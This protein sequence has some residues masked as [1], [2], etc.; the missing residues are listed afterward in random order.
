MSE[1]KDLND[2][3]HLQET[4]GQESSEEKLK[5][6][7]ATKN[8][9]EENDLR[10]EGVSRKKKNSI[11]KIF[12]L[13]FGSIMIIGLVLFFS[14]IY[15]ALSKVPELSGEYTPIVSSKIYDRN[16]KLITML[17]GEENRVI[18]KIA[19]LPPHVWQ[20]F[21][22]AEDIRFFDHGGIDPRGLLRAMVKNIASGEILE[23]GSTITQQFVKNALLTQERTFVRKIQEAFLSFEV[24]RRYDK[25]EILEFYLN[26]IYFGEGAYGIETAAQLY[27]GKSAKELSVNEVAVL[28]SI[29][30]FPNG[31]NPFRDPVGAVDRK[32]R[33]L[34]KMREAGY[35]SGEEEEY[36]VQEKLKFRT[37]ETSTEIAP[38]FTDYILQ[39]LLQK[40]GADKVYK[41]GIEVYTTLDLDLQREAERALISRLPNLFID[42][43]GKQQAQGSL[44][45]IDPQ[46][47]HI[48]A[49]VGGRGDDK[50]NR[51]TLA[52]RQP[53]SAFKP[54]VYLAA[55]DMGVSPD[56]MIEDKAV[57]FGSYEPQNYARKFYGKVSLRA[58]L[59]MS[60]NVVAVRLNQ[61]VT[62]EKTLEY[63]R[64]MGI[65]TLV[66]SGPYSDANLA[67]ALGGLSRGVSPLEMTAAF[68]VIANQGVYYPP[69]AITKVV[70]RDGEVLFE[71]KTEGREA[72]PQDV[73]NNLADMMTGVIQSGTG[74][75]AA[76]GRPA[77]GKT[78]TT[79]DY[80][81]AWFVGFSPDLV[82]S[83][84]IGCDNNVPLPYITGGDLPAV[85]WGDFMRSAHKDIPV[86][87]FP[88]PTPIK[89]DKNAK[90]GKWIVDS[91]K[92]LG[93][94]KVTEPLKETSETSKKEKVKESQE[95]T[96]KKE[97]KE[98]EGSKSQEEKSKRQK[99][100]PVKMEI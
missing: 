14:I 52:I 10:K 87:Y 78:G 25:M 79:D 75:N 8:F 29:P 80:R 45:C 6:E 73:A 37:P 59:N 61:F 68:G 11:L 74:G 9:A 95:G 62:P 66:E 4:D 86:H 55:L 32:D 34:R 1:E 60:L 22:A 81:D 47:G 63:A 76:I 19:D 43:Q 13:S 67:M 98:K 21:V 28:A 35:I 85:I 90:N 42:D 23:G 41:E 71:T 97:G 26:Q 18:V 99:P 16:G 31:Y 96:S 53:G 83:V 65:S 56:A 40:F 92:A 93:D 82:A 17:H 51:A 7:E 100:K 44:V 69:I 36:Y 15:P 33:V 77:A 38:Y 46:N 5:G 48:L 84:W 3:S 72:I 94:D 39:E 50:Y 49:L 58:A 54:F 12:L 24:E 70:G 2:S 64:K 89:R 27:Y 91:E 20:S 57:R 88:K 30:K